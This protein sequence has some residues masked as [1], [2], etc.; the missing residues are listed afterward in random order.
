MKGSGKLMARDSLKTTIEK[1][2]A[3]ILPHVLGILSKS[4][5][6]FYQF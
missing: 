1:L 5:K 2:S 4:E 3:P 6:G